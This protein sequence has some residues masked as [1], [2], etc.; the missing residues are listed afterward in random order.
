MNYKVLDVDDGDRI[1]IACAR[2]DRAK[3][4]KYPTVKKLRVA[5]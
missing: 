2:K 1:E 5:P 3:T 4:V